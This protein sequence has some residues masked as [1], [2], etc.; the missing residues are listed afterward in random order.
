MHT[1]PREVARC[2]VFRET[3]P[4]EPL[5][6]QPILT[7]WDSRILGAVYN[8]ENFDTFA[9]VVDALDACEAASILGLTPMELASMKFAP[10]TSIDVEKSFSRLKHIL[11]DRRQKFTFENLKQVLS[12]HCNQSSGPVDCETVAS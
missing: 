5:P 12:V 2:T 7:R 1:Q 11:N 3:A 8:A 10:I 9:S 4:E 6:P